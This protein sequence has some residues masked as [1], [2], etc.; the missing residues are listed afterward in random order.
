MEQTKKWI[1]CLIFLFLLNGVTAQENSGRSFLEIHETGKTDFPYEG[2]SWYYD[3]EI[4]MAIG[5]VDSLEKTSAPNG[6]PPNWQ[7]K[8]TVLPRAENGGFA[9]PLFFDL[10]FGPIASSASAQAA[11]GV[12][13]IGGFTP[14][15]LSE[16][17]FKAVW[18]KPSKKIILDT[19]PPLPTAL[20]NAAAVYFQQ[21]IYVAGGQTN[22]SGTANP[23]LFILDLNAVVN[24]WTVVK[25]PFEEWEGP[26]SLAVQGDGVDNCLYVLQTG[27]KISFFKYNLKTNTWADL[28][29]KINN[30]PFF[31]DIYPPAA[32]TIGQ[33]SILFFARNKI[34][35]NLPENGSLIVFN[36]I[37][38][39]FAKIEQPLSTPINAII[40]GVE[41]N[42]FASAENK[43]GQVAIYELKIIEEAIGFGVVNSSVLVLY[44]AVMLLIG[45]YFSKKQKTADD[46]FKGGRKIPFWAAGLSLIGTGLS[47]ISF[48]AVPAKAFAT[49]WAY[50]VIRFS[51]IFIPIIMGLL[52]IP[53]FRRLDV[54]TAYEYLQKRFNL[55]T[56]LIGSFSFIV[57]QLGRIGIVLFLP[58]VALN[59]VTG[60]DVITCILV[61]GVVSLIY[62]VLGGIEAVIWTDV[63]QVLILYGGIILCVAF[64]SFG[65]DGGVS[66]I[67][68]IGKEN[69]KFHLFDFSFNL[70]EPNFWVVVF[71][72]FFTNL[73]TYS[74]DQTMVQRYLTTRT[75]KDATKSIW[76]TIIIGFVLGWL[77]FFMGTALF[78]Y[79]KTHPGEMLH[80]MSS[81]DAVFPWYIISQLPKGISGLLIAGIFAAAMSSLSSS[82]NSA[83]TAYTMDFH[84]LFKKEFNAV[85][86]GRLM[87]IIIGMGGIL[88]AI[89]FASMNVKSIWDEFLKIIGLMTGGLGGVFLLGIVTK[90]ANGAGVLIGLLVSAVVQYFVAIYQPFNLLLFTASGFITCFVV[91]YGGSLLLPMYN[92]PVEGLTVYS[93]RRGS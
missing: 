22:A 17:V 64:I 20:A 56:R 1:Q 57:F 39:T 76:T 41:K 78:A 70:N 67:I 25:I 51:T 42:L 47:A 58:A 8:I 19:L 45:L 18:D 31:Q 14:N 69:H 75:T 74:A 4:A 86:V 72:S 90:K 23:S 12:Y 29:E 54:S 37:T 89:L 71:G 65:L 48:M 38:N 93:A 36:T 49:D 53:V 10:P 81:N 60:F 16:H 11:D 52:Y 2:V 13:C 83:A 40:G 32:K 91:G 26:P 79:Y 77:F 88:F 30:E 62:T 85:A 46:Y 34:K 92:K 15:G 61:V 6:L 5:G 24:E 3:G 55:A 87:T 84:V 73:T 66:D 59:V 50:Y 44:F 9:P 63:I 80:T 68:S 43:E 21:K 82:M 33:A 28:R 27:K 7:Q 35:N